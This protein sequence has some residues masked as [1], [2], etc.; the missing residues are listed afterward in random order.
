VLSVI[1]LPLH[2]TGV[3]SGWLGW[4]FALVYLGPLAYLVLLVIAAATTPGS[5]ADRVRLAVVLATM[6][7]SWGAGFLVGALRGARDVVDRSRTES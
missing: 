2:L 4:L 5:L 1:L 7:L 3:L 6:H